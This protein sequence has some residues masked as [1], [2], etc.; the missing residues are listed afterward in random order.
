MNSNTYI[1]TAVFEVLT[2]VTV[3]DTIFWGREVTPCIL[4]VHQRFGGTYCLHLYG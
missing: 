2:V 1:N 4:V 3:E